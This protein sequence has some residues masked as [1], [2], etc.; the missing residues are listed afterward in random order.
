[1]WGAGVE[2]QC[3]ASAR[4]VSG[5]EAGGAARRVA[6]R[7]ADAGRYLPGPGGGGGGLAPD[8]ARSLA[9]SLARSRASGRDILGALRGGLGSSGGGGLPVGGEGSE[10]LGS[11]FGRMGTPVGAARALA[12]TGSGR[13]AAPILAGGHFPHPDAAS[14]EDLASFFKQQRGESRGDREARLARG[15]VRPGRGQ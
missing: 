5:A 4:S 1:M 9:S 11:S 13:V 8:K 7:V 14:T 6:E 3:R 2:E 15:I 12:R 10:L